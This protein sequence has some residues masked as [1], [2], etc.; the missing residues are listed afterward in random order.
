M[1]DPPILFDQ[2]LAH[3]VKWGDLV[4]AV[5]GPVKV[6]WEDTEVAINGFVDIIMLADDGEL[7]IGGWEYT[8]LDDEWERAEPQDLKEAFEDGFIKTS[9]DLAVQYSALI[10]Q[11]SPADKTN[12]ALMEVLDYLGSIKEIDCD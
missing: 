5:F 12:L 10:K 9:P 4:P 1:Y 7:I 8:T 6:L 2:S 3:L 11:I